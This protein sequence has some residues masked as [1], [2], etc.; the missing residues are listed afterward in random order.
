LIEERAD[1]LL[2]VVVML[3]AI[4]A[5]GLRVYFALSDFSSLAKDFL[6]IVLVIPLFLLYSL[7]LSLSK[8]S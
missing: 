7:N 6:V 2:A 4:T 1:C 5:D 8:K 3:L